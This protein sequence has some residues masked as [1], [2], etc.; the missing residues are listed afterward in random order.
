[1]QLFRFQ[2][3]GFLHWGFNFW[4]NRLSQKLINPFVCTDAEDAFPSGDAFLVYP[5]PDG[6]PL[7]SIH[8]M[9]FADGLQDLRALQ[10]LSSLS[11]F[12]ET[13]AFID[14]FF[15]SDFNFSNYPH[16]AQLLLSVREAVNR[17]IETLL[18]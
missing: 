1:M 10:L 9:V 17:K 7:A 16:D 18:A 12:K 4:F 3:E 13:A 5:G 14:E 2:I 11:D 6:H 15:G 8:Q